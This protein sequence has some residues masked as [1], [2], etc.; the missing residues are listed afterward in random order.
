M[1]KLCYNFQVNCFVE[2][3]IIVMNVLFGFLL[4]RLSLS[5]F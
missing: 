1:L 5:Y 4:G 2:I 3:V